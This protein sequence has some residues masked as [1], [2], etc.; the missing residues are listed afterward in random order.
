[1]KPHV[2]FV[3]T[4]P[5][6]RAALAARTLA[7]QA[8]AA[9]LA[10][11]ALA[12][13]PGAELCVH[14]ADDAHIRDLN[15]RWRGLDKATNVLS[16]PA[17]EPANIGQARLLGDIVLAFETVAREAAAEEKALADHYRHLVV[18][19]FLHLLGFDHET[20]VDAQRMEATETRILARLGVADPYRASEL[21]D[22]AS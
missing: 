20:E 13:R 17:A 6:W 2:E 4:S 8:I 22:A 5:R 10:E 11:C 9:S 14:L 1:M 19:G 18:H 21:V 7:R 15:A 3:A 16:F 12:L